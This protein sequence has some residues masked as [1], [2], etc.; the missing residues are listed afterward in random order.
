[1]G[2]AAIFLPMLSL[3]AVSTISPTTPVLITDPP[4][5]LINRFGETVYGGNRRRMEFDFDRGGDAITD[6]LEALAIAFP[7]VGAFHVFCA[8]EHFGRI[9]EVARAARLLPKPWAKLKASPPPP[10]HRNW[11]PSAFEVA[12]YGYRSGAWFGDDDVKRSN[13]YRADSYRHGIR[14]DEKVDHPTQKWLP[15]VRYLVRSIASPDALVIDPFMGSGTTLRAAKDMARKA[16][17]I[18]IDER[19]C[20]MAVGRLAQQLLVAP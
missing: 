1:M 4:Y 6:V 13:V 11:W 18:E 2:I 12:I 5:A 8:I 14:R 10:M 3:D 17:G 15:M 16:I 19:Y 7:L 9:A 20:E